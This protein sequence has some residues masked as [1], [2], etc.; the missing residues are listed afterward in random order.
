[1]PLNDDPADDC[2]LVELVAVVVQLGPVS[3][4]L[5]N[6]I[7]FSGTDFLTEQCSTADYFKLHGTKRSEHPGEHIHHR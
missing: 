3:D 4:L 2:S 6:R 7:S 5:L 1:M